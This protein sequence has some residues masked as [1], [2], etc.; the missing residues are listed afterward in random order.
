HL[1]IAQALDA[2]DGAVRSGRRGRRR[3]I[4]SVLPGEDHIVSGKRAAIVPQYARLEPPDD[5]CAVPRHPAIID[6]RHL[7]G[8]YGHDRAI[9]SNSGYRLLKNLRRLEVVRP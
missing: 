9:R 3:R 5:P 6:A 7:G 8:E 2:L 4:S 1:M